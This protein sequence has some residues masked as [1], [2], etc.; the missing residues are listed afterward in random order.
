MASSDEYEHI[1]F[2]EKVNLKLNQDQESVII[3]SDKD[4][5]P[6]MSAQFIVFDT[7]KLLCKQLKQTKN[8]TRNI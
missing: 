7:S 8:D 4:G 3:Q 1:D 2:W 6:L 5:K